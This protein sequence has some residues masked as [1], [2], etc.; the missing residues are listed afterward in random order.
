MSS[1]FSVLDDLADCYRNAGSG[2]YGG[3]AIADVF[4]TPTIKPVLWP[5]P[6]L[7]EG[8]S[9]HQREELS[10]AI[11]G[12]VGLFSGGPGCGKT[13]TIARLLKTI[14]KI[15]PNSTIKMMAPTGKAAQRMTEMAML[16]GL[17]G[18]GGT[19][20]HTG[21]VPQR[22]GHDGKG[23]GFFHGEGNPI[24]ANVI[25]VDEATMIPSDLMTHLLSAIGPGTLVLFVGDPNQLPPVG[26]GKPYVDMISAGL[27]HG[28]LT[29]IHRFSGR[30]AK[31][32]QQIVAG[33]RWSPSP[34]LDLEHPDFPENMRHVECSEGNRISVLK[35]LLIRTKKRGFDLWDDVQVLCATNDLREKLNV[36]LQEMLNPDGEKIDG[37]PFRIRDK[38]ICTRNQWIEQDWG[39]GKKPHGNQQHYI[40]NGEIGIVRSIDKS[41]VVVEV[42]GGG[43]NK[44]LRFLKAAWK[45]ISLAYAI[46]TWKAQGSQ[47]QV[48]IAI[49]EDS[50]GADMICDASFWITGISRGGKYSLTVGKRAAIDRQC[51]RS[52]L[53]NRKTLLVEKIQKWLKPLGNELDAEEPVIED[54]KIQEAITDDFSDV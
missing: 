46:T 31:V 52:G 26:K 32:C 27:P 50:R 10:K 40:A 53:V 9:D 25:V 1:S 8:I 47:Y 5:D 42:D 39:N 16:A 44:L 45:D 49:A 43:K 30:I 12:N 51:A 18:V 35:D 37:C 28:H 20:I 21:L 36:E 54:Q 17:P 11:T 2:E 6:K 13:H 38:I 48:A 24:Y 19:T 22:N 23:W 3:V 15:H 41:H 4:N 29:E 34:S 33:E 14:K 7:I